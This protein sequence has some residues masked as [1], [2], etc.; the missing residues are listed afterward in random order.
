MFT[1]FLAGIWFVLIGQNKTLK[2]HIMWFFAEKLKDT[3]V[4]LQPPIS[5]GNFKFL[6]FAPRHMT[7]LLFENKQ[8]SRQTFRAATL[9][10]LYVGLQRFAHQSNHSEKT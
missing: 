3:F 10:A 2:N 7:I 5:R 9:Y 6:V 4:F 1:R 8:P